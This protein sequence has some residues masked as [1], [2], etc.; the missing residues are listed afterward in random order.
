LHLVISRNNTA[1]SLVATEANSNNE[2]GTNIM[3]KKIVL[4]IHGMGTHKKEATKEEFIK[5]LTQGAK[6]LRYDS[7]DPKLF[8]LEE[9]NYSEMLDGIRKEIAAHSNDMQATTSLLTGMGGLV[10]MAADLVDI[11]T[12][13][14]DDEF[15]YTHLLDVILYATTMHGSEIL[16]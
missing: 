7:F 14:D 12:K 6:F 1:S 8:Q 2:K 3:A 13:F 4:L 9:F 5:G 15:L 16:I 10:G 11:Q